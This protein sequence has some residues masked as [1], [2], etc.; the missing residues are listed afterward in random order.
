MGGVL[1]GGHPECLRQES[2]RASRLRRTVLQGLGV[3]AGV[4]SEE[5]V[6]REN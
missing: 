5:P 6:K 3:M 2:R 4:V 1:R